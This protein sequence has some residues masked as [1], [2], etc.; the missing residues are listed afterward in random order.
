MHSHRDAWCTEVLLRKSP[1]GRWQLWLVLTLS[2]VLTALAFAIIGILGH[3]LQT[4]P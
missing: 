4:M 1:E 3:A 2:V